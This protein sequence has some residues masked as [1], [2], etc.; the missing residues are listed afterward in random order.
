VEEEETLIRQISLCKDL[1]IVSSIDITI[2]GMNTKLTTRNG[3]SFISVEFE[4]RDFE[5]DIILLLARE[6][7]EVQ[8]KIR[9][10]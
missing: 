9:P 8:R 5:R 3:I 6:A 7:L 4:I 10:F 2:A 1:R